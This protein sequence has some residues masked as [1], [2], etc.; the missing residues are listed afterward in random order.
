[1]CL[2]LALLLMKNTVFA[3]QKE[4]QRINKDI[5]SIQQLNIPST[6]ELVVLTAN[7]ITE[8]KTGDF[9]NLGE[10]VSLHLGDNKIHTIQAGAFRGLTKLLDLY[11]HFNDLLTFPDLRDLPKLKELTLHSNK[12]SVIAPDSAQVLPNNQIE[13][14]DLSNMELIAITSVFL[15]K[16]PNLIELNLKNNQIHETPHIDEVSDHLEVLDLSENPIYSLDPSFF[17]A[18]KPSVLKKFKFGPSA[19]VTAVSG[20]ED[21]FTE[22]TNLEEIGIYSWGLTK[23]PNFS[24]NTGTLRKLTIKENPNLVEID[25]KRLFGDPPDYSQYVAM[26]DLTLSDNG[27]T[28]ISGEIFSAMTNLRTLNLMGNQLTTFPMPQLRNLQSLGHVILEGNK[29]KTFCDIGHRGKDG[30]KIEIS[31]NPLVCNSKLCWLF[32]S[33]YLHKNEERLGVYFSEF[34]CAEPSHMSSVRWPD[35]TGNDIGCS[36]SSEPYGCSTPKPVTPDPNDE[37]TPNDPKASTN[38]SD[39]PLVPVAAGV[40]GGLVLILCV[41]IGVLLYK[42]KSAASEERDTKALKE[43]PVRQLA[44]TNVFKNPEAIFMPE[45]KGS[46]T[47]VYANFSYPEKEDDCTEIHD[48]N[49]R[50]MQELGDVKEIGLQTFYSNGNVSK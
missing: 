5:T 26:T 27:L 1:M 22:L 11:L 19:S 49:S 32:D 37:G 40:V 28:H 4:F 29:L 48:R 45:E 3:Q 12:L 41:I 47:I 46:K 7:K 8:L 30:L 13:V 17:K 21:F 39:F 34:P 43:L 33:G 24:G 35:F 2:I 44:Q 16:F 38:D 25:L 23:L 36:G 6:V 9:D 10:C 18:D 15:K 20:F 14:L 42:R 50:M 31:G